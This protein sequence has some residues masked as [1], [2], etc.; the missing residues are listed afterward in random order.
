MSDPASNLQPVSSAEG[1]ATADVLVAGG[2]LAG[3]AAAAALG[4][5]GFRVELHERRPSLGGRATSYQL[6]PSNVQRPTSNVDA[7][8][9]PPALDVGPWTLDLGPVIDNCQ[10]V[11]LGCC[12]N[13]LDLYD[14]LGVR[15]CIRFYDRIP[16]I[17]PDGRVSAMQGDARPAPL[18]L[19]AS[20]VRFHPLRPRDRLA[21][22]AGLAAVAFEL[23]RRG[24]RGSAHLDRETM[25]QWLKRHLQTQR[26]IDHFWRPVLTSALNEKPERV[27]AYHGLQLFWLGF[28][29]NRGAYHVGLP[30]VPLG[31]L[32]RMPLP[33]VSVRLRSTVRELECSGE[34]VT[35]ARLADGATM[36]ARWFIV[37]LPFEETGKLLPGDYSAFTH[38][39]IVGIHLWFDRPLFEEPFAALLDRTIHWAFRKPG[40]AGYVQCVV[41]AARELAELP[42]EEIVELAVRQLREFFPDSRANLLRSAVVKE[43]RATYSAAPGVEGRRP[44]GRTRFENCFLAGDWTATAWPPTMESAV[45]SGYR[46]AEMVGAQAGRPLR[47]LRPELPAEGLSRLFPA[48]RLY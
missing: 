16:F 23:G 30:S 39:P 17:T 22:M 33:G 5:A 38:S 44:S 37:A 12:T 1:A 7:D 21:V 26:A 13:L 25:L 19:L 20:L 4:S 43:Q 45:R 18:H 24:N 6:P 46:A 34:R 40:D 9:G 27:S 42:K 35:T 31:E 36:P 47:F 3:I 10:H 28:L 48:A 2:G 32:Y 14:R 15:H 8:L 11:L 41:S 29:A